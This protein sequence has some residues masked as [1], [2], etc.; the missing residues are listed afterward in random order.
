MIGMGNAE[1]GM[2][3]RG[4]RQAPACQ[5]SQ[6]VSNVLFR[7]LAALLV[8]ILPA[9][10]S[11]AADAPADKPLVIVV[12]GAPG[13]T[14]YGEQFNQWADRWI[15]AARRGQADLVRIGNDAD[16]KTTDHDRLRD[17]LAASGSS[18]G[19]LWL[20]FLGHG[21]FDG[22]QAKFNLRGPDVDAAELAG[23]CQSL[24][25]PLAII[26]TSSASGPMLNALSAPDR[27]VI[28]ATKSGNEK[29]FARF[30]DYFSSAIGDSAADLDKDGQTSLLEAFLKAGHQVEEYYA[31]EARLATEHA[32]LDDNGDSLGTPAAWFRGVRDALCEGWCGARWGKRSALV[33]CARRRRAASQ[34]RITQAPRCVGEASCRTA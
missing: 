16:S 33:S 34:S 23:W 9:A 10:P 12:V 18:T 22:R 6:T 27:V 8:F 32:L 4:E 30:G 2:G 28:V 11:S 7:V 29:N 1:W 13:E 19:P 15:E 31:G 5:S 20:V 24:H 21:T 26:D 3:N 17:A 14:E 25:R